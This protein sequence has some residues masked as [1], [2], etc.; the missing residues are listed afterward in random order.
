[1]DKYGVVGSTSGGRAVGMTSPAEPSETIY[2][3]TARMSDSAIWLMFIHG[4]GG[5]PVRVSRKMVFEARFR[6]LARRFVGKRAL[7][8]LCP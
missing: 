2:R 7:P 8:G 6:R 5:N 3:Y 1:M 4:I